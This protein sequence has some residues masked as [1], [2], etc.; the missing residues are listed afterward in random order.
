MSDHI[1]NSALNFQLY[2]NIFLIIMF[3]IPAVRAGIL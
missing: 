2:T 1:K 3:V